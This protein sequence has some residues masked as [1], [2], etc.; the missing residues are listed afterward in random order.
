MPL[1]ACR[2]KNFDSLFL[3]V[4]LVLTRFLLLFAV[5]ELKSKQILLPRFK[6]EFDKRKVL[7][8]VRFAIQRA[9]ATVLAKVRLSYI[10]FLAN[11]LEMILIKIV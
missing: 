5:L 3:L 8:T 4:V 2:G 9:L 10:N 6:L 11:I 1:V 7:Q